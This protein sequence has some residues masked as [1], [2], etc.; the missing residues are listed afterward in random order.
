LSGNYVGSLYEDQAGVLWVGTAGT[1]NRY[2][3]EKD[4]FVE[5]PV[6]SIYGMVH[7]SKGTFWVTAADGLYRY[8]SHQDRFALHEATPLAERSYWSMW[9][10]EDATGH[11]W[12][13]TAQEGLARYDPRTGE[14]RFYQHDPDNPQSL[15]HNHVE[16]I[17]QDPSGDWW[18]G[19]HRGLDLFDLG[20]ETF[21]HY[22]TK[23]GLPSDTVLGVLQDNEGNLWLSTSLGLSRFDP[24][25]ETFRNYDSGDGLQG[26]QF[27]RGAF[28]QSASGEMFFGGNNGFNAF[29][30]ELFTGNPYPPPVAITAFSVFNQ[31]VRNDPSPDEQIDLT[32]RENFVSFDF[33]A[34]D[35]NNPSG[36]EYAFRM[37]GVDEDWVYAGTRRHADYPNLRPG[38]YVFRVKGSNSDGVWNEEGTSV[39][40]TIQPPFWATWWFRGVLL[41]ALAGVLSSAYRLRVRSV[42]ARSRE[43]EA[44]V[45]REISQRMRVEEALRQSEMEKAVT[46]ERSRLARE[47]HDAVTQ[48]LFSA[49]LIAEVLPRMWAK[50]RERG[51]LQLEEV[52]LLTRGALAEMRS[53]LLELRPEALAQAK[54]D[55]LLRQ[56]GRAMT[57]RTGVPVLVSADVQCPLSAEVQVALYRIAQEAL[58]NAAKHAEA[59]QVEVH[60]R[61]DT[62]WATLSIRDD[63]QG[64]DIQNVPPGHFGVGIMRERAAAVGAELEIESEPRGGT[65]VRVVWGQGATDD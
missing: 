45:E 19:T 35:Y 46:A 26:N 9:I 33:A 22:G 24:E 4:H 27:S 60:F 38:D 47:L 23:E 3:R 59:S 53:L 51:Q 6:F 18:V 8:D 64:F 11:L 12:M 40:I 25:S 41:L 48:T 49:S 54:M 28:Y 37:E 13:G 31:V 43:L 14:W 55:D 20:T 50:D 42:E 5:Y 63:G 7:D 32:H 61:C 62:D 16:A 39:R 1:L 52:R 57:G 30:P 36:N 44:Q 2:D 17:W 56:L 29:Y 58:N 15:S 21:A 65:E 34:L 10:H